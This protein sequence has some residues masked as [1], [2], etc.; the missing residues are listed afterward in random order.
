MKKVIILDFDGVFYSSENKFK[1]VPDYVERNRRKFLPNVSDEE[2]TRICNENPKF[3]EDILR[4][5]VLALRE[6]QGLQWFSLECENFESIHNHSA[7]AAHEEV[8]L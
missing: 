6:L 1:L 8:V 2:Y 5:G 4:D 3:V 7:Y